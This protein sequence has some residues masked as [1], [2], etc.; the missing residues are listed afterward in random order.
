M[1]RTRDPD[2]TRGLLLDAAYEEIRRNGF[3][4]ASLGDILAE[5][6][7]TK[8]AL[9]HH[10]ED[11]GALGRAVLAERIA[12][13]IDATWIAPLEAADDPIDALLAIVAGG[14]ATL[15]DDDIAL[16]CPLNNLAVEM[17]PVDETFRE[18][19][20]DIYVAWYTAV[21]LALARGQ[22]RGHVGSDVDPAAAAVFIVGA[23]AGGRSM[24]KHAQSAA[25]LESSIACLLGYIQGLRA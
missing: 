24:A 6:G 4:A 9:Y 13:D 19:I 15:G 16:G 1:T 11:K 18:V 5:T 25:I 7:V 20:N 14:T 10:F 17:S 2:H 8:G 23:L 22:D 3:Q 12:P 21:A